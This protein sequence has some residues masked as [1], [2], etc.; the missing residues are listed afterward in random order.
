MIKKKKKKSRCFLELMKKEK[1]LVSLVVVSISSLNNYA[2]GNSQE[3][4]LPNRNGPFS[5]NGFK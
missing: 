5:S 2:L 4:V 3:S 1:L